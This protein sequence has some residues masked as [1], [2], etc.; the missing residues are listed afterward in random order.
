[1]PTC[2]TSITTSAT[3]T[4]SSLGNHARVVS[5]TAG[6]SITITV[7]LLTGPFKLVN[8]NSKQVMDVSGSSTSDGGSVIQWPW[9]TPSRR[10]E[11]VPR[12][13]P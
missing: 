8:G 11:R 7:G 5:L 9:P 12:G 13:L 2:I 4:A 3:V 6:T 1:M 10:A